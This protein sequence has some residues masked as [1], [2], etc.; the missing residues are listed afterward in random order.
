MLYIGWIGTFLAITASIL[1]SVGTIKKEHWFF[2]VSMFVASIIFIISSLMIENI[3]SA[4]SNGFFVLSSILAMFGIILKS[5][6]VSLKNMFIVSSIGFL[7][8]AIYYIHSDNP[9]WFF[10]SLG[11]I[12]VFTLPF[13]FMLFTQSKMTEKQ[14][15]T[16]NIFTHSV[17][18]AHLIAVNNY[19][20]LN[21]IQT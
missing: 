16:C 2:S 6:F 9:I 14:Y 4:I 12:P 20:Y 15:F 11:W 13:T 1:I 18:F 19:R 8:S 3:Q 10:Q 17:F 21:F 7:G 5:K